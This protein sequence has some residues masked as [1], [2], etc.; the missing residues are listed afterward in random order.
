MSTC[1]VLQSVETTLPKLVDILE[2]SGLAKASHW[3]CHRRWSGL[4]RAAWHSPLRKEEK[5]REEG[6]LYWVAFPRQ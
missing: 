3:H 1:R 4:H 2:R 6:F 5:S